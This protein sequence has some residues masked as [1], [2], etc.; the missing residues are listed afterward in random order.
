MRDVPLHIWILFILTVIS[1]VGFIYYAVNFAAKKNKNDY[2]PITVLTFVIIWLFATAVLSF[3]NFFI[4]FDQ[5]YRLILLISFPLVVVLLTMSTSSS[6]SFLHQMPLTT[7]TYIHIVRVPLEI[8]FWWLALEGIITSKMTF[9]G[10][11]YDILSGIS[12]PFAAIFLVGLRSK[13]RIG[14][15]I[16]NLVALALSVYVLKT[17]LSVSP[18]INPSPGNDSNFVLFRFPFVWVF[19]FVFPV[20]IGSHL[21]S[22]FKIIADPEPAY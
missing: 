15:T 6:R 11:N 17:A 13:S 2:T 20:I 3:Y 18:Y 10:T 19:G 21:L 7:L 4:E 22:L 14:A 5:L 1:I 9:E 12:A 8:T 16:W